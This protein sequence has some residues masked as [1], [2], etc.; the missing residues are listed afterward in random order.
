MVDEKI[1]TEIYNLS[2]FLAETKDRDTMCSKIINET[3][4]I[5][6]ADGGSIMILQ[7]GTNDLLIKDA[8]GSNREKVIG[9]MMKVGE[10]VAGRAAEQKKP[11]LV[12][13]DVSKDDRFKNLEKYET[14]NSGMAVPIIYKSKLVGILNLK[15]TERLEAF[16][17]A[18]VKLVYLI[19]LIVAPFLK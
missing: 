11:I 9:K 3:V 1:L 5:L 2:L 17:E 4:K 19:G 12:I 7:S 6:A 15:R 8:V 16:T 10:R 18:D 14:I 13:G